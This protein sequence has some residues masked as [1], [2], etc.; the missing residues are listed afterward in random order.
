MTKDR[1]D[2]KD[3]LL[4]KALQQNSRASLVSLARNIELSRSATHDRI[5]RLEEIGVIKKYTIDVDRKILPVTRAFLS[6][7]FATKFAQKERAD[8]IQQ[9][10]GVEAAYCL[11][12][13]IDM[14]AYCEC[15]T[16]EALA[17]LRDQIANLEGV[18]TISTRHVLTTSLS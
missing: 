1:L 10:D 13:D 2:Q 3:L 18:I 17:S 12:G 14:L 15:S 11:S 16:V 8:T 6:I 7:Q 5:T 4:V 9:F